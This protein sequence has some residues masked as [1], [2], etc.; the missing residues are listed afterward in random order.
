MISGDFRLEG[1]RSPLG[2]GHLND[3]KKRT[4]VISGE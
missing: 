1:W 2:D 4:V 3:R